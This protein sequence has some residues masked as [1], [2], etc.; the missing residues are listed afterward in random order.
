[1]LI[2]GEFERNRNVHDPRAVTAILEAAEKQLEE[3]KHPDPYHPAGFPGG[4]KWERNIP[5]PY[6][7]ISDP[8]DGHGQH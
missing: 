5:P 8:S 6:Q 2:R 1:M 4:S 3:N 7:R